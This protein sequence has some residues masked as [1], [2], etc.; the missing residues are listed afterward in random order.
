M[1]NKMDMNSSVEQNKQIINN[2]IINNTY[3]NSLGDQ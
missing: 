1:M 2:T 3:N